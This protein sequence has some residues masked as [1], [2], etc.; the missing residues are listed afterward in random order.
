MRHSFSA[1]TEIS[2]RQ[3]R[4]LAAV[5]R[6]GAYTF[7]GGQGS[8]GG[9][10]LSFPTIALRVRMHGDREVAVALKCAVKL[11]D[12]SAGFVLGKVKVLNKTRYGVTS[13]V[14]EADQP[15]RG[16]RG[17]GRTHSLAMS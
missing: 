7:G 11:F 5:A 14:D 8:R 15:T 10:G 17:T 12:Q 4:L 13:D 1:A 9:S 2:G 6:G 16:R 3:R